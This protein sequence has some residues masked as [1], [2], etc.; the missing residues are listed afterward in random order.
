MKVRDILSAAVVAVGLGIGGAASADVTGKASFEGEAPARKVI[1]MS[2][3]KECA[4]KHTKKVRDEGTIVGEG[5]ALKNVVVSLKA[6][7]AGLTPE[8][9]KEPAVLDQVGCQYTPHVVPVMVGQAI[10]VKNS[11]EFAHNVHLLPKVNKELN[12]QQ[13]N[14]DPGKALPPLKTPEKFRVKCDIHPWMTAF[15]VGFEHPWYGVSKDDGTFAMNTAGLPDGEYVVEAWHERLGTK[16]GK[17]TV[18]GGKGEVSFTFKP[19]EDAD[20][21]PAIP[22]PGEV[23]A[24]VADGAPCPSGGACC[25]AKKTE[26]V[27]G[28]KEAPATRVAEAN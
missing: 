18:K 9:P 16:E 1:D 7:P 15:I 20:A 17:V 23:Q 13:P 22:A 10:N 6:I 21:T 24:V 12:I 5:G 14:V 3:V 28:K 2:A 27:V 4:A 26:A 19:L 8:M 11:D 25:S